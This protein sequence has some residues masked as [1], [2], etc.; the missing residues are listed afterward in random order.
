MHSCQNNPE[1]TSTTKINLHT[2]SGYSLFTNCSSVLRGNK[3]ACYRGKDCM[4]SFLLW[5]KETCN[6]NN[7]LWKKKEMVPLTD[8][9]NN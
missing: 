8:E 7:Q 2:P 9:E 1:K 4:G 6:K 3:L 5:F